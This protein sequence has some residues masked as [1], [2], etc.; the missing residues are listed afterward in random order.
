MVHGRLASLIWHVGNWRCVLYVEPSNIGCSVSSKWPYTVNDPGWVLPN[1]GIELP[2]LTAIVC[3]AIPAFLKFSESAT[4]VP[5]R[6][7]KMRKSGVALIVG[8][9]AFAWFVLLWLNSMSDDPESWIAGS[10]GI[11]V[12]VILIWLGSRQLIGLLNKPRSTRF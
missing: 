12:P 2:V 4:A 8:V 3:L 11:A 1:S 7:M 9:V 6:K 5:P 10:I